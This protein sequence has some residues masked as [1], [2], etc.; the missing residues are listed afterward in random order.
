MGTILLLTD[1]FPFPSAVID[2]GDLPDPQF[3]TVRLMAT[4]FQSVAMY[5]CS[6]GYE[7]EGEATRTCQSNAE[8]SGSAPTC[9]REEQSSSQF[10]TRHVHVGN[11]IIISSASHRN[12]S[13][14]YF[15]GW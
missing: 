6:D 9:R 13:G 14:L 11:D 12:G 3:G 7:L 10:F 8:W 1:A 5:K 15:R 2:C 4:I